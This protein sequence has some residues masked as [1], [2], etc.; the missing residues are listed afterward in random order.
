MKIKQANPNRETLQD[1]SSGFPHNDNNKQQQQIQGNK[2][3][4]VDPT[5]YKR[6]K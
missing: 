2:I 5:D 1:K 4:N 3:M 6:L